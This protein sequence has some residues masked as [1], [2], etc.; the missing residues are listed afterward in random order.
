MKTLILLFILNA[1]L[2]PEFSGAQTAVQIL[3][4]VYVASYESTSVLES[5]ID[6]TIRISVNDS[7]VKRLLVNSNN[8]TVK[9]HGE[10][11]IIHPVNTG[12]IILMIYNYNDLSNP[13]LI[14]ERKLEV[15][16]APIVTLAG[17][18]GGKI[19]KEELK[20]ITKLEVS[21]VEGSNHVSEFKLSFSGKDIEYKEFNVRDENLT[22][23]MLAQM[24]VLAAGSKIYLEYIKVGN[25]QATCQVPPL[26]F[27]VVE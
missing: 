5:G 27:T 25:D 2:V 1:I 19:T 13:V 12:E 24:Q 20:K 10:D 9:Q 11:F 8:G 7:S 6:N 26:V 16:M 18:S 4:P 17:K 22:R 14:E 21:G 15:R 3:K 23:E